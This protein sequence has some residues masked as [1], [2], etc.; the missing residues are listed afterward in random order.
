[1]NFPKLLAVVSLLTAVACSDE[2]PSTKTPPI[3]AS[4]SGA[5]GSAGREDGDGP[6]NDGA[7]AYPRSVTVKYSV[8]SPIGIPSTFVATYTD[9]NGGLANDGSATIPFAATVTRSVSR[10]DALA[11]TV[12]SVAGGSLDVA[13]VVDGATV[14][15]KTFSGTKAFTGTSAYV[16]P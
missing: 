8:T 5:G 14:D 9:A 3:D 6:A 2:P 7:A 1:M 15:Q 10:G 16:F 4:S 13:I 11:F 12:Q